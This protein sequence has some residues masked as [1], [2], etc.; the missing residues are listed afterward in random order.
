MQL[1]RTK[2]GF[3]LIEM[4]VAS[5]L[6]AMVGVGSLIGLTNLMT[7]NSS[8]SAQTDR[9]ITLNR[10]IEYIGD[11]IRGSSA[12][13]VSGS[14]LN[15]TR[16]GS[17]ITYSVIASST[18]WQ[19]PFMLQRTAAGTTDMMID[20]LI[21]PSAAPACTGALLSANG[22]YACLGSDGRTVDLNLF[23]NA[24]G[25]TPLSVQLSAVRRL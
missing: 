5:A 6:T 25:T 10:A 14:T 11:D 9:R 24:G 12:V 15:L 23:G 19:A 18:G 13:Q 2:S 8:S 1:R 21:P 17:T 4:L 16:A 22:F 3:S 7:S 20:G